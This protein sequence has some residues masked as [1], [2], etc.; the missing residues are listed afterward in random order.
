MYRNLASVT[1]KDLETVKI[2]FQWIADQLQ[3]L[4]PETKSKV[5]ILM[6][7]PS[8]KDHCQKIAE[9]ATKLGMK[10]QLRVTSAHKGTEESLKILSEYEGSQDKV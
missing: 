3:H 4:V 7:S 6:G 9:H 2:N 1:E 8:D 5:V 10:A